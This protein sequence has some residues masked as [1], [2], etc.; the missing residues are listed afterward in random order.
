MKN[1]LLGL[2]VLGTM[3]GASSTQAA[4]GYVRGRMQ[5][6]QNQGNY[7]PNTRDCTG[8]V[9]TQAQFQTYQ[10][11]RNAR[12]YV[13][14]D[15]ANAVIGQ[16]A[17]DLNGDYTISWYYAGTTPPTGVYVY[18]V[19]DHKDGRFYIRYSNG[20][21]RWYPTGYFTLL[22]G[23]TSTSPQ[24]I[25]TA[26]WGSSSY[27]DEWANTYDGAELMWREGLNY[28]GVMQSNFTNVEIRGFA[29]DMP[30]FNGE[31]P[32]S[33]A[34]GYSK[35]VQLDVG[36][37][38]APQGRV[39]HEMGHIASYLAHPYSG[40]G[41]NGYCYPSTSN[42]PDKCQWWTLNTAEHGSAAF[43]EALATFL[44]DSALYY[45]NAPAPHSCL[46]SAAPCAPGQFNLETSSG[47]ACA[48]GENRWPLTAMRFL[49]DVYDSVDDQES[50]AEG[51]GN[52]WKMLN[53]MALYDNG[54]ESLQISE[55]WNSNYSAIDNWDGRGS[56]SYRLNY[57][58]KNGTSVYVPYSR[59]C[60]P[61]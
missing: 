58:N 21:Y 9:Y 47:S 8:A 3:L 30:G 17:T 49:W 7:C 19:P 56:Y 2:V 4:S 16:G 34:N 43:E 25:G 22:N 57:F 44:A 1:L 54:T 28:F 39:M 37:A 10:P 60:S 24:N 11:V 23:T 18:W 5:F 42:F 52:Y 48:S 33:C 27:A 55:P 40:T 32:T 13:W 50:V 45:P 51:A 53:V 20:T 6:W 38:Y 46:A 12:V 29:N 31:C 59:N 15:Q 36:A 14:S 35:R 61:P 26:A 41:G